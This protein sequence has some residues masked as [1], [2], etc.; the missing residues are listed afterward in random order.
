ME[1]THNQVNQEPGVLPAP[2]PEMAPNVLP[3]PEQALSTPEQGSAPAEQQP[4]APQQ[5]LLPAV[6]QPA[7]PSPVAA[8]LTDVTTPG[9]MPHMADDTDLIEKEWVVK[10]KQIVSQTKQD[11]Y[12]QSKELGKV[13]AE[14]IKKRYNKDV[15][16]PE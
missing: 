11:P 12:V 3:Q 2:M 14:Y 13:R 4:L 16:L 1:P 7:V 8:P 6:P 10:A 15:K 9:G 5:A